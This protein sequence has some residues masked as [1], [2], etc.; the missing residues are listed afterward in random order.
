M[1]GVDARIDS[2]DFGIPMKRLDF[3]EF[4]LEAS[5]C[6]LSFMASNLGF[7]VFLKPDGTCPWR[8]LEE[9]RRTGVTS[10]RSWQVLAGLC[11]KLQALM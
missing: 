7:F 4:V 1:V 5:L 10:L 8:F 6:G 2:S 11:M 3:L 9:A